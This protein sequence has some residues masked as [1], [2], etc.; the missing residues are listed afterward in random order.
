[1]PR[2]P[3]GGAW[4]G[5][6]RVAPGA[7]RPAGGALPRCPAAPPPLCARALGPPQPARPARLG[8]LLRPRPR[9]SWAHTMRFATPARPSP[10][11]AGA[12]NFF[13]QRAPRG[14]R[15]PPPA[16]EPPPWRGREQALRLGGVEE[17]RQRDWPQHAHLPL[18]VGGAPQVGRR[19]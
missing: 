5:G 16:R 18:L 7:R 14:R 10:Q 2:R 15:L 4:R 12:V 9:P 6:V 8:L 13:L 17:R 1:M 19:L 3:G 11:G